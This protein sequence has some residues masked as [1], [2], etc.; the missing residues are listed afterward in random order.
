L[1]AADRDRFMLA[2]GN[3]ILNRPIVPAIWRQMLAIYLPTEG[4]EISHES[5][6][7]LASSLEHDR[8]FMTLVRAFVAKLPGLLAEMRAALQVADLAQ[9]IKQAHALADSGHL[10]GYPA[11]ADEAHRLEEAILHGRDTPSLAKLIDNLETVMHSAD[12]GI[13]FAASAGTIA[14]PSPLTIAA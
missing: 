2:G 3:G 10:Y 1:T 8:E 12:R 13:K 11:L 7:L 9:L 4:D 6:N 5:A 14:L